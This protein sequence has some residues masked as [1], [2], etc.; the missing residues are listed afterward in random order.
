M[1]RT[2]RN[3][4]RWSLIP[5]IIYVGI[6]VFS[7]VVIYTDK[8]DALSSLLAVVVTLL[9]SAILIPAY[10]LVFP[11]A[12]D[13]MLP[14]TILFVIAALINTTLILFLPTW[15]SRWISD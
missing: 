11:H 6:F 15:I 12:F 13:S 8:E 5:A 7:L 2:K 3:L 4:V 1:T 10:N 14:G 9:W